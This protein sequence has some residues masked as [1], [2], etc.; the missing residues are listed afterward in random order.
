[1]HNY[2]LSYTTIFPKKEDDIVIIS[3]QKINAQNVN[4]INAWKVELECVL[5]WNARRFILD[6]SRI[7][8]PTL[9]L[10]QVLTTLCAIAKGVGKILILC[11]VPSD[12]RCFYRVV[13]KYAP[14]HLATN[15]EEAK[16]M[17]V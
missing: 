15:I 14:Y 16:N 12:E 17:E 13:E 4:L 1:M 9:H 7:S 10:I 6:M 5:S 11:N 8:N 3:M 2:L